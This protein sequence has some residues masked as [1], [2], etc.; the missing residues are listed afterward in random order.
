MILLQL[1]TIPGDMY[2]V[3]SAQGGRNVCLMAQNTQHFLG[4][5][6]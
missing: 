5:M 3:D 2:V 6:D 4:H 1:L